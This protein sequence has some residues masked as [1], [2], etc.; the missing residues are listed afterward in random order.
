MDSGNFLRKDNKE[1]LDEIKETNEILLKDKEILSK[2]IN[3]L[4]EQLDN[5]SRELNLLKEENLVIMRMLIKYQNSELRYLKE[6][7][8]NIK[9]S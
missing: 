5:F 8:K 9:K 3:F 2:N 7:N 1:N 4:N 6:I